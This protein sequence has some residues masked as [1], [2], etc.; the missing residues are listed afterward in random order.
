MEGVTL[1]GSELV[2]EMQGLIL[3]L[4]ADGPDFL[5][6]RATLFCLVILTRLRFMS[7]RAIESIK[8]PRCLTLTA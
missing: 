6:V 3:I 7:W 8:S 5:P 1:L 2:P 4:Q